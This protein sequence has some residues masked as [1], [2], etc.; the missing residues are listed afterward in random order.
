MDNAVSYLPQE[1]WAELACI[2]LRSWESSSGKK[3]AA[4]EIIAYA[5]LQAPTVLHAELDRIFAIRPNAGTYFECYPWRKSGTQHVEFLRK[6]IEDEAS[7]AEVSK[8]RRAMLETRNLD[9]VK[10]ALLIDLVEFGHALYHAKA[11]GEDLL[12]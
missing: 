10:H 7:S 9:A 5:S 11:M 2:A 12:K 4:E 1:D 3:E 8:G 6:R